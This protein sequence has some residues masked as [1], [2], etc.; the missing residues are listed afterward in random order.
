MRFK[1]KYAVIFS[2]KTEIRHRNNLN[3]ANAAFTNM[4]VEN[5]SR[6]KKCTV[7]K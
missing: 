6:K 2:G 3:I 4:V 1:N 7:N 5:L